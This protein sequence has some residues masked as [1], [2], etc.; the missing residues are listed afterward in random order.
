MKIFIAF[1]LLSS[2][3]FAASPKTEKLV[4]AE[5]KLSVYFSP[6]PYTETVSVLEDGTM[7]KSVHYSRQ[8]KADTKVVFGKLNAE[9]TKTLSALTLA[10]DSNEPLVDANEGQPVCMDAP[11]SQITVTQG[12]NLVVTQR[13]FSCHTSEMDS[14]VAIKI[15]STMEAVVTLSNLVK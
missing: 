5:Y 9:A 13:N 11:S 6:S 12:D 1:L 15:N 7:V 10:V 14:G 8:N 3:A 2:S 4:L